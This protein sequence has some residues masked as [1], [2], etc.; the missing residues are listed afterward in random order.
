MVHLRDSLRQV[1]VRVATEAAELVETT[2]RSAV[3]H[4]ETKSSATDPV[5]A[6][7]RAA[8]RL[9][10]ERLARLRPGDPVLGEEEGADGADGADGAVRWVVDPID[11]TVNYLYGLPWYSV[12]VAAQVDGVTVAGAVVEPASGRVWSAARGAGA[13]LDDAPLRVSAAR[14][15]ALTLV[16]TGF[17]Y[18][19]ER[20]AQQTEVLAR[21]LTRVR[22]IRRT[23]SAALDLCLVGAGWVDAYFEVGLSPWD[24]AAGS[25]IA[26]EAGAVVH[27]P[28]TGDLGNA[29]FASAPGVADPLK[30][31]LRDA[32]LRNVTCDPD[33]R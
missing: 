4:V 24:W 13:T 28:G 25:L 16:A 30:R 33:P 20:R 2:R 3:R 18:R 32:G 12:S 14:E 7:D 9:I 17:A 26:E 19:Q 21:L 10:R 11:G 1:A 29:V 27:L 15:L 23:G 31:L 6:G 22:D 8:E 5:T